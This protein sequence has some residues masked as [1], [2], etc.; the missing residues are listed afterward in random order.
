MNA[1]NAPGSFVTHAMGCSLVS[2][3]NTSPS[4]IASSLAPRR[5]VG[6][7]EAVSGAERRDAPAHRLNQTHFQLDL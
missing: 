2:R 3:S 5:G 4:P 6:R 7:A 1:S